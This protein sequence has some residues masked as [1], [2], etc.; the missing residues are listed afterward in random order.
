MREFDTMMRPAA[1]TV[2]VTVPLALVLKA[3]S[4]A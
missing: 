4:G 2:S 1:F 3:A